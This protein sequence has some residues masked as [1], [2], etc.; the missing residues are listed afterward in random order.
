MD[1][2]IYKKQSEI[3]ALSA[4]LSDFSYKRHSHEEYAIGVTLSGIQ[5]YH[6]KGAL[7]SSHRNGIML[8]N[9]EQPHDGSAYDKT[10]I[11]YVMLYIHPQL[12]ME[13]LGKKEPILFNEPIVYNSKL[14]SKILN[15]TKAV[16]NHEEDALCSD[17]LMQ[18]AEGV[19]QMEINYNYKKEPSLIKKS[20]K[21]ITSNYS[22]VLKLEDLSNEFGMSK[23]QFIRAFKE[24]TGI[25]PYQYFL[26]SKIEYARRLIEEKKDVYTAIEACGFTDI[27]HLNKHFK[28]VY[29]I[30]AFEYMTHMS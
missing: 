2:F 10:G 28:N 29:G 20:K 19:S 17:L 23:F 25:S 12:M 26:N 22:G 5:Q 1:Q 24:A 27:S 4:H 11:D 8:F 6:L 18:V 9:P 3:M 15:L 21:I 14:E 16:L 13:I 30:T 7:L